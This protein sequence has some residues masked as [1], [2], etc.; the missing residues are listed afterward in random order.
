MSAIIEVSQLSKKFV[1]ATKQEKKNITAV[2]SISFQIEKGAAFGFIGPNG[3]GKSTTIKM[4][5]G[6]LYPSSGTVTVAGLTPQTQRQALSYRIGCVFGQR[7]QL[8]YN[9]PAR[10]SLELFG[11]LYGVEKRV[12]KNRIEELTSLLGLEEFKD[13]PVRKLSLG[14]RMRAEIS[15]ALIH[16]PEIIFLDEPTIGLDVIAKRNL[17]DVLSR[18]NKEKGTTLFLTSHDMGD[19][20]ALAERTIVVNHGQIVVDEPTVQL[21]QLFGKKKQVIV[22][23]ETDVSVPEIVGTKIVKAQPRQLRLEVDLS[24]TTVNVVLQALMAKYPI[25]DIDIDK[26]TLESIIGTIYESQN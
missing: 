14:Q 5:T 24:V 6:I 13:Q 23:F 11:E 10:D 3:A 26:P 1:F 22:D 16:D 9:L 2:D 17:R 4:L 12:L 20:E 19:I 18:L 8:L 15:C 7:S 25:A 21:N